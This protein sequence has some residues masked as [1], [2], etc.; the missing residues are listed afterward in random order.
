ML[1]LSGA[2]DRI[3]LSLTGAALDV[4]VTWVDTAS[5]V[6][7]PGRLN[8]SATPGFTTVCPT[9]PASTQRNAKSIH[10]RNKDV[11]DAT[12]T[13]QHTDGVTTIDLFGMVLPFGRGFQYTDQGGFRVL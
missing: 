4:H 3:Q 9:P 12:F 7:T 10:I 11:T 2:G 1:I 6:I 5:G 13:L 8:Q